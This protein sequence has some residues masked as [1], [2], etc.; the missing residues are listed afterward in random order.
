MSKQV[1]VTK[2]SDITSAVEFVEQYFASVQRLSEVQVCPLICEELLLHLL[3]MGCTKIRVSLKGTF[4]KHIEIRAEGKRAD[5]FHTD[6][7][8]EEE[9]LGTFSVTCT[10]S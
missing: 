2:V 6:A 1:R 8:T 7:E 9:R 4:L 3:N 10:S 5:V